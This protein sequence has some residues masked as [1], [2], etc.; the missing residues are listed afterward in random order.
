M[1]QALLFIPD[2][3]GY[4]Q[5]V[6]R[7]E[8][9]HQQHIITE[10]L[11]ILIDSNDLGLELAEV[12]GDALFYYKID[13]IPSA[14]EILGLVKK[15]FVRFHSHLRYYDKNRICHC[16]ACEEATG[17]NLKFVIHLGEISFLRLKGHKPKPHG[18]E[19]ITVHRLLKNNIDSQEY[20]LITDA[21]KGITEEIITSILESPEI[22]FSS[23]DFGEADVGN[24]EFKFSDLHQLR[25]YIHEPKT[26]SGGFMTDNPVVIKTN[27]QKEPME[28][29]E[30]MINF[31]HRLRWSKGLDKLEYNTREMNK[32]G[33]K[34]I[35]VISNKEI[36][37][38]T[39][40]PDFGPNT[41]AFG[42]RSEAPL[43][44]EVYLYYIITP[45]GNSSDLRIEVHPNPISM[46]GKLMLPF[47][48]WK[49]GAVMKDAARELK[50]YAEGLPA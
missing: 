12:E 39:I 46:I 9:N 27:I 30:V 50:R 42:E 35:C 21:Y 10:L 5:F 49:I 15:M 6:T 33:S 4:T 44:R 18:R 38:D 36:H 19:V 28:L 26:L 31:D 23:V 40:K 11:D 22:E 34:H 41:W 8:I 16:G 1:P 43:V 20:A 24:I 37:V 2:I 17:L 13:S 7:T 14:N 48:K 3:S 47:F 29:F 32:A 45:S 25:K